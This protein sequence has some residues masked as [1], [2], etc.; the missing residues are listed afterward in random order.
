MR[1][2]S[3]E[4]SALWPNRVSCFICGPRLSTGEAPASSPVVSAI[5]WGD[6]A[7]GGRPEISLKGGIFSNPHLTV[8]YSDVQGGQ[9]QAHVDPGCVLAWGPG[10][11]ETDPCFVEPGEWTDPYNTPADANDDVWIDGNYHLQSEAGR[12][13]PNTSSWV[14]DAHTSYC[15]D[16]GNPGCVLGNEPDEPNNI[17][18]NM[19]VYGGTAEASM[20]PYGWTLLSDITNDGTVDFV[21]FA[22]LADMFTDQGVELP[23]DFDRDGDVD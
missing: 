2:P 18:V 22:H 12:W 21:D 20:P 1:F 9:T 4:K 10:N 14:A 13:D 23:G 8:S 7:A 11:I 6:I 5:L 16:A 19:G 15:I 3:C 17:R